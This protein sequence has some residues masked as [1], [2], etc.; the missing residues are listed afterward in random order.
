LDF[1]LVRLPL[2]LQFFEPIDKSKEKK[3]VPGY[4][5]PKNHRLGETG[6]K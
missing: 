6:T 2:V 5:T 3:A 1:I 4:R